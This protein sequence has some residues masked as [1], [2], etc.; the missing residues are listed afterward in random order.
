MRVFR[1]FFFNHATIWLGFEST[2]LICFLLL[3][4]HDLKMSIK[5]AKCSNEAILT[6]PTFYYFKILYTHTE[7]SMIVYSVKMF[8]L[9]LH[10]CVK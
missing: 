9:Y 3:F 4:S 6:V 5:F 1:S 7:H 10:L 2:V 8:L